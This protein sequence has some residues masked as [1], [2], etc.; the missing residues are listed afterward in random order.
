VRANLQLNYSFFLK[1]EQKVKLIEGE[2]F[3]NFVGYDEVYFSCYVTIKP[4]CKPNY[5]FFWFSFES[6][7]KN[8]MNGAYKYYFTNIISI[9]ADDLGFM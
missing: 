2:V 5:L 3:A 8:L 1:K 9:V 4:K 6:T 7:S